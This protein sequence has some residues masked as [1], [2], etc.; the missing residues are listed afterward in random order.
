[1]VLRLL[2]IIFLTMLQPVYSETLL[3]SQDD[4]NTILVMGDSLSAAYGIDTSDGW[5]NLLRVQLKEYDSRYQ[6]QVINASVSGDTTTGGLERLPKLMDTHRPV[7]CIIA[8]GANDGLRGQS[9]DLMYQNLQDMITLCNSVG[10]TLLIGIRLPPNYGERYTQAF[11]KVY[12]SLANNNNIELVA[13][14]LEGI[15]L[16]DKYFQADRLHP[17]AAAQPFILDTIWAQLKPIIDEVKS[18]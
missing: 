13:F 1:M 6:W 7:L 9:L 2:L 16:E 12:I 3:E 10:Q 5:V 11:H 15:A 14:M 4:Q 18:S 8:L 17:T